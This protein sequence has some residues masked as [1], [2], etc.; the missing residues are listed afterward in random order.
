[1]QY[2]Q[3]HLVFS[4]TYP[5]FPRQFGNIVDTSPVL[6]SDSATASEAMHPP[7]PPMTNQN[8]TADGMQGAQDA[9]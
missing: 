6:D 2:S 1:M 7:P 3:V 8:N 4:S 5:P 9:S